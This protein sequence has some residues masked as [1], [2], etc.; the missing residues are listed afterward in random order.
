MAQQ[1]SIVRAIQS[2]SLGELN[3]KVDKDVAYQQHAGYT[4][5]TAALTHQPAIYFPNGQIR[6]AANNFMTLTFRLSHLEP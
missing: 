4:L 6:T 2:T 1:I 3:D 5:R